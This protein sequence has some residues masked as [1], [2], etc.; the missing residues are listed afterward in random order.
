M[1]LLEPIAGRLLISEPFMM[2]FFFDKS[3]V[4]LVEHNEEGSIGLILNK[5]IQVPFHE[6][7][8]D[9]PFFKTKIFLGGPVENE[10]LFFIHRLGDLIAN[11]IQIIDDLYWGGNINQLKEL[12]AM[13]LVH[14]QDIRF[15][16]GYSGWSAGQL[17]AEI[18]RK[19]WLVTEVNSTNE[20]LS[21]PDSLRKNILLNLNN[22]FSK[23]GNLP[24]DPWLN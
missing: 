11:S 17:K 3:V 13:N 9:F 23:W 7:V 2:N 22:D 6:V 21:K 14:E 18:K 12:I 19:T 5:A 10:Q 4:L 1:K 20:L 16:L 24:D 15:Y 8:K